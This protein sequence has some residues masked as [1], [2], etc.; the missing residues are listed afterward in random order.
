MNFQKVISI[1]HAHACC[2][3]LTLFALA[4]PVG[5]RDRK[6]DEGFAPEVR[7]FKFSICYLFILFAALV[8][9]RM[10]AANGLIGPGMFA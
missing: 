9:D 10:L 4:L 5:L 8:A 6:E 7:L 1:K 3:L 2:A